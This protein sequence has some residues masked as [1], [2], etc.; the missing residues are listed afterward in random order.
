MTLRTLIAWRA[1]VHACA[2]AVAMAFRRCW[3]EARDAQGI[4]DFPLDLRHP[5]CHRT[6][7]GTVGSGAGLTPWILAFCAKMLRSAGV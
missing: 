2:V 4:G 6:R 3:Y 1:V 7:K 5:R